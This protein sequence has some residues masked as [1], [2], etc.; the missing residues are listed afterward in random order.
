M[1]VLMAL[2]INGAFWLLIAEGIYKV[3]I[4]QGNNAAEKA[5]R[6]KSKNKNWDSRWRWVLIAF[7]AIA[8]FS[9]YA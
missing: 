2:V 4:S 5:R 1:S 9:Q 3:W 7:V 8:T 6:S